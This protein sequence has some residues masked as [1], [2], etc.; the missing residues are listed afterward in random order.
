MDSSNK[1]TLY[2]NEG[3]IKFVDRAFSNYLRDEIVDEIYPILPE[4]ENYLQILSNLRKWN[5]SIQEFS[6]EYKK[7]LDAETIKEK[8][9]DHVLD[10]LYNFSVIGNQNKSR[11]EI[12]YFKYMHTNMT[13]NRNENIVI[14]RGLFK[15]LQ[16]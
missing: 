15:A 2:I 14:H 8:N 12:F 13:F 9:I 11:K 16:L 10:I 4:I 1:K 6:A 5:F 7:Y 3:T